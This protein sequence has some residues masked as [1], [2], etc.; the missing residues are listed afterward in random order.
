MLVLLLP[1]VGEAD[2]SLLRDWNLP[3]EDLQV[4]LPSSSPSLW[5]IRLI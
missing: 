5:E 3:T 4:T 2:V 1:G